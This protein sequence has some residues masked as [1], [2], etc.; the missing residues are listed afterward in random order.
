M[1][2]EV[3]VGFY[4]EKPTWKSGWALAQTAQGRGGVTISVEWKIH[5]E[6]L[7][8]EILSL[9]QEISGISGEVWLQAFLGFISSLGICYWLL[10][11]GRVPS[12][13]P[14]SVFKWD[15]TGWLPLSACSWQVQHPASKIIIT[16]KLIRSSLTGWKLSMQNSARWWWGSPVRARNLH[17]GERWLFLGKGLQSHRVHYFCVVLIQLTWPMIREGSSILLCCFPYVNT[18]L[19]PFG[20]TRKR[21]RLF[22]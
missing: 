17:V 13:G 19:V 11:E 15:Q 5:P 16:P 18:V 7:Y 22:C 14:W 3:L 4:Y 21:P 12:Y 1:P 9:L 20:N 10:S 2:G 6:L 8:T